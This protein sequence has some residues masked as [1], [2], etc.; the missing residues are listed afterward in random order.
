MNFN[1][2]SI[3]IKE[4]KDGWN[5]KTYKIDE[6]GKVDK[7]LPKEYQQ[8][9]YIESTGTQYINSETYL[10]LDSTIESKFV[11]TKSYYNYNTP[12][13]FVSNNKALGLYTFGNNGALI[14]TSF[15][16]NIDVAYNGSMMIGPKVYK[17]N[18]EGVWEDDVKKITYNNISFEES[19]EDIIYIFARLKDGIPSRYIDMRLYYFNIKRGE[20]YVREFLP[21]YEINENRPGLYDTVEGKFYT[22]QGTGEFIAG[23]EV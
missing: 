21:V 1:E 10:T 6:N 3:N 2:N 14:Y 12:Y 13:G 15:G 9:E 5:F 16:N 11:S 20:K 23:P 17:H 19:S 22:N 8:V 18:K 4:I 7:I